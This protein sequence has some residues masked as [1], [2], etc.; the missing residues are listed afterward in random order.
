VQILNIRSFC[1]GAGKNTNLCEP[2]CELLEDADS[3]SR[4]A[5]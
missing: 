5:G 3:D 4:C 2:P 1:D